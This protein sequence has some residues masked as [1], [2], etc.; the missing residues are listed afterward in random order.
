MTS[1]LGH[2]VN[3]CVMSFMY[4]S[5]PIIR[6][7]TKSSYRKSI[8]ESPQDMNIETGPSVVSYVDRRFGRSRSHRCSDTNFRNRREICRETTLDGDWKEPGSSCSS[9]IIQTM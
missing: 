7:P 3:S 1:L 2:R 5:S 4:R 6:C 9:G 8:E